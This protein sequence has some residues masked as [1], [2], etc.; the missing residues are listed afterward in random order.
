MM[1]S[2][3]SS[4]A[5]SS[6]VLWQA[7]CFCCGGSHAMHGGVR[8]VQSAITQSADCL[9]GRAELAM[10]VSEATP[11]RTA[12]CASRAGQLHQPLSVP[13]SKAALATAHAH[14][15]SLRCTCRHT[16]HRGRGGA[17]NAGSC[18]LVHRAPTPRRLHGCCTDQS[19]SSGVGVRT[20]IDCRHSCR[21]LCSL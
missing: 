13:H 20:E 5:V 15:L 17:S 16:E 2:R 1:C 6:L 9:A 7:G 21:S 8:T 10:A 3:M 12:C 4:V 14:S 11:C 18:R 19:S